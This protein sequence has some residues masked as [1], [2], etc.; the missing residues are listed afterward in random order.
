MSKITCPT[1]VAAA[2]F[3]IAPVLLTGC[4]RDSHQHK[5]TKQQPDQVDFDQKVIDQFGLANFS[6]YG[7]MTQSAFDIY[8]TAGAQFDNNQTYRGVNE[9]N[10]IHHVHSWGQQTKFHSKKPEHWYNRE[11]NITLPFDPENPSSEPV[12]YVV[13][14]QPIGMCGLNGEC[15]G[16]LGSTEGNKA[17]TNVINWVVTNL[18][19]AVVTLKPSPQD[20]WY[21]MES[22]NFN[23]TKYPRDK[24]NDPYNFECNKSDI[25]NGKLCWNEGKNPDRHYLDEVFTTLHRDY[26]D[27]IDFKNVVFMGYSAGSQ[28][29]SAS[30]SLFPSMNFTVGGESVAYPQPKAAFMIAGG[31][32]YCYAYDF[33]LDR[34]WHKDPDYNYENAPAIYQDFGGCK[35]PTAGFNWDCCPGYDIMEK[36]YMTGDLHYADHPPVVLLQ[37]EQ[38]SGATPRASI[39]YYEAAVNNK[40]EATLITAKGHFHGLS[41]SQEYLMAK[42]IQH[43]FVGKTSESALR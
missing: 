8:D 25:D 20:T 36:R 40:V 10:M 12:G 16:D 30:M 13:Y 21:W 6:Y 1:V 18:K 29:V 39:N 19:M 2:G 3:A 28:M 15:D 33:K 42:L 38:D 35:A 11:F 34:S 37:A 26:K 22:Y 24:D 14:F 27:T 4:R 9:T 41:P 43:Y 5:K 23:A 31:S 7:N 17:V 32:Q